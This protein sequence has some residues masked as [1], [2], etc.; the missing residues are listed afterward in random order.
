MLKI[1]EAALVIEHAP[2]LAALALGWL[3]F[4]LNVG[5]VYETTIYRRALGRMRR[6]RARSDVGSYREPAPEPQDEERAEPKARMLDDIAEAKRRIEARRRRVRIPP[7]PSMPS[8]PGLPERGRDYN[9]WAERWRASIERWHRDCSEW[10]RQYGDVL[11][12]TEKTEAGAGTTTTRTRTVEIASDAVY[13]S[14]D[15]E[16]RR[17]R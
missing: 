12:T 16:T 3:F 1:T 2:M 15:Y 5:A 8:M 13:G 17:K 9:E 4:W 11:H 14:G 6:R 10:A 7:M